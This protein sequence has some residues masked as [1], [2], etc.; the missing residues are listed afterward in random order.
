ML[1]T[2]SHAPRIEPSTPDSTL[3]AA[4]PTNPAFGQDLVQLVADRF[5]IDQRR[6]RFWQRRIERTDSAETRR[7]FAVNFG[8]AAASTD[9]VI[10]WCV[11]HRNS[12][13]RE[14]GKPLTQAAWHND[15]GMPAT[16][17]ADHVSPSLLNV[18]VDRQLISPPA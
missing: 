16:Y 13:V 3:T 2:T 4:W 8:V 18:F 7:D 15:A 12:T 1:V 5:Q 14:L 10:A 6:L 11:V 9:Q 17:G